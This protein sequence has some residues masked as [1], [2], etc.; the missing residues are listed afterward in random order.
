MESLTKN[1]QTDS[2]LRSIIERAYGPKLVP[3]GTNFADELGYGWFNVTYKICLTDGR[4]VV[5]KIAPPPDVQVMTYERNLMENEV[6]A[7]RLIEANSTVPIPHIDFADFTHDLV[8]ANWF[9]MPFIEGDNYGA[10]MEE[11]CTTPYE[12]A[13]F[14]VQL[15]SRNRELNEIR[16]PRFG[17]I[18]N[19]RSDTWREEFLLMIESAI[20]DGERLDV[21]LGWDYDLVR[22]VIREHEGLLD[23]VT[24]PEF[25]EWDLWNGNTIFQSGQIAAIIDHERAFFGD[26]LIEAC[27]TAI[28]LP[29]FGDA[30]AF[31]RGYGKPRLTESESKRRRLYTL[32]LIL[33]MVIETEYR[34]TGMAQYNEARANLDTVMSLLGYERQSIKDARPKH[35]V[36]QSSSR[37]RI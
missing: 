13:A 22:K 2:V 36:P 33:I 8:N 16:G 21:D 19:P 14:F 37:R 5:L 18:S 20:Q 25:C 17:P 15:G 28:D 12:D 3:S 10:L 24:E 23:E 7:M 34:G 27:F 11:G 30:E 9:F 32:Y 6:A 1:R 31:M 29:S 35:V 4:N 26:P